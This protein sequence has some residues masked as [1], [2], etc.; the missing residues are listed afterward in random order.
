MFY[1]VLYTP[2]KIGHYC[3]QPAIP[4]H[5]AAWRHGAGVERSLVTGNPRSVTSWLRSSISTADR[6]G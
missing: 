1:S 2:P 6:N 4:S 3:T 5:G